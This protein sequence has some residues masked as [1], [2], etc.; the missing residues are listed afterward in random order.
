MDSEPTTSQSFPLKD[1]VFIKAKV[2][3]WL[4]QFNTFCFLDSCAFPGGEF[5]F[6]AGAGVRSK[7]TLSGADAPSV[8]E[9][10]SAV[11]KRWLLGHLNYN[12]QTG[13]SYGIAGEELEVGF[14]DGFFFEPEWMLCVKEG[15]FYIEGP[16]PVSL[17]QLL[18]HEAPAVSQPLQLLQPI[19]SRVTREEYL[20]TVKQ[21][22]EHLHRGDCYEINYC[23]EFFSGSAMMDPVEIYRQ[24][25]TRSPNPFSGLYRLDDR[26]LLCASPERF[27]K[28]SGNR[29][30]SQPIKG[31]LL[32]TGTDAAGLQ[33]ERDRLFKSEKD[34]A[35]NVMVVDLVRNDLSRICVEGSVRV[36]EL[37]GIYSFAQVHQMI[38]TVSGIAEP[39][40][41]M[42]GILDATFPMGS[43]TGAPKR[44]VM[45]LIDQYEK[46]G[47]GIFS[48]ALGYIKPDGDFD[49]NVIIRSLMYNAQ[50]RYLSYKVG[51]GI[52]I[53]SNP[54]LE[55]EECLLKAKAIEAVLGKGPR[56]LL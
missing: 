37:F 33:E 13:G 19:R 44:R 7:I 18:I 5:D 38:S 55:W 23:V 31:T 47:R 32:R 50:T 20:Q 4:R 11:K 17:Y 56:A 1:A 53:Y 21:L 10:F 41:A 30:I 15:R 16:D 22:Q 49:F 3:N 27:L 28:K 25:V 45:Q 36:D 24:L 43:M 12:L 40:A 35:E 42:A 52:T 51:S 2:L 29:L 34:R 39:G 46:T 48:G 26:W 14:P 8:F 9:A 54:E 6:L